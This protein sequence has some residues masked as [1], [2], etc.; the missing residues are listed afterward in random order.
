MK[1]WYGCCSS[2]GLLGRRELIFYKK[3][4]WGGTKQNKNRHSVLKCFITYMQNLQECSPK[5]PYF[6]VFS[7][8]TSRLVWHPCKPELCSTFRQPRW[9]QAGTAPGSLCSRTTTAHKSAA[10][11]QPRWVFRQLTGQLFVNIAY[12]TLR[13]K[14]LCLLHSQMGIKII[15]ILRKEKNSS[16]V[17]DSLFIWK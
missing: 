12:R 17:G 5:L 7:G 11:L 15:L 8:N 4:G 16:T 2:E 13:T 10:V 1:L 14:A 3:R 9:G 6:S